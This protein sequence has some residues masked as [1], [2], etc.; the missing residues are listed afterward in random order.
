METKKEII[1]DGMRYVLVGP[2]EAKPLRMKIR[3]EKAEVSLFLGDFGASRDKFIKEV[4]NILLE[5]VGLDGEDL[6]FED[7]LFQ[8]FISYQPF[9]GA[10]IDDV[11]FEVG[12]PSSI[13]RKVDHVLNGDFEVEIF[14][15]HRCAGTGRRDEYD[16][17]T[18]GK[19]VYYKDVTCRYCKGKGSLVMIPELDRAIAEIQDKLKGVYAKARDLRKIACLKSKLEYYTD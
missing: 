1:V 4:K 15:C 2:D 16:E 8:L 19:Q 9:D 7:N 12:E 6:T 5:K 17:D 13:D 10:T 11:S 18:Y 14:A 3:S